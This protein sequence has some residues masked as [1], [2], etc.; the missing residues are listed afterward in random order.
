VSAELEIAKELG[1]PYFLLKGYSEKPCTA[2]TAANKSDKMY[3]WTW[4][5][6]KRLIGGAR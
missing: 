3:P 4:D 2:P 6:L 1:K 5:N